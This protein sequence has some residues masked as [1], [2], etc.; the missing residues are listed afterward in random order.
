[1]ID[2]LKPF[3][4]CKIFFRYHFGSSCDLKLNIIL[5]LFLVIKYLHNRIFK[6][7]MSWFSD[8]FIGRQQP[9]EKKSFNIEKLINLSIDLEEKIIVFWLLIRFFCL[10]SQDLVK[11]KSIYFCW[12]SLDGNDSW[13]SLVGI[14]K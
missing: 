12:N 6:I 4:P 10:L 3:A 9:F 11:F 2:I 5:R 1:M 8:S 13:A 7:D 14:Y